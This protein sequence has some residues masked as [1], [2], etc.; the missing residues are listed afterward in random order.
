MLTTEQEETTPRTSAKWKATSTFAADISP[1]G[2]LG[3]ATVEEMEKR[4]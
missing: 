3:A 4:A 1:G 2:K